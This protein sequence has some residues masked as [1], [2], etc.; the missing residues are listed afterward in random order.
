MAGMTFNN[1]ASL[2]LHLARCAPLIPL[3]P[4][5]NASTI[6][7]P[8]RDGTVDFN[9]DS[10]KPRMIPVDCLME[11]ASSE[12]ELRGWL[13]DVAVW[14]SGSGYLIFDHDTTKQWTAKVYQG[15]DLNRIPLTSQFI[16]I[17]ECQPYAEAV[18]ETTE[19]S[20]GSEV[21][22]ASDVEFFPKINITLNGDAEYVQ[23]T[24]SATGEYVRIEKSMSSA[25]VIA[26]NMATGKATIN[27]AATAVTKASNFF[28]VPTGTQTI[29]V[30]ATNTFTANMDYTKRYLYA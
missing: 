10:Y 29:T 27:G 20:I 26:I 9:N 25:D 23:V 14:L 28:G 17:F 11:T 13:A 5:K 16:V 6:E 18:A 22:Y 30:T 15:I 24:L 4:E 8:G 12:S 19:A 3:L 1:I 2:P 21:D 7:I